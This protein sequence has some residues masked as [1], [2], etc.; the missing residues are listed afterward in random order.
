MKKL[1]AI[2]IGGI[3]E[4]ALIELHDVRIIAAENIED[5]YH[6]LRQTWWGTPESL[7]IDAWG[8]LKYV[9]G[10][11]ITL[12]ST[13]NE[14]QEHKLYFVNL[15]GYDDNEFTELHKN[16]FVVAPTQSKAKVRGLKQ[17]LA[18]K[19]HHRDYQFAVE[20]IISVNQMLAKEDVYIHLTPTEMHE[21][22]E[23][24]CKYL[25]IGLK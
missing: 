3:H 8:E 4:K 24:I 25:P 13:P 7:H 19:S 10:Y 6:S 20:N 2:Y 16:V 9:D 12:E 5:C 22:F 1:F 21:K 18:W 17:I 23:F 15:G 14:N 11:K